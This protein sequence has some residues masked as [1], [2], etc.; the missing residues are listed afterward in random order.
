V[1][2]VEVE[3]VMAPVMAS[4]VR[5]IVEENVPAVAPVP[6][7]IATGVVV[8]VQKAEAVPKLKAAVGAAVMVTVLVAV[9]AAQPPEAATVLV[10]VK[11]PGMEA[12]RLMVPVAG[13]ML[14]PE[15]DENVPAVA[16]GANTTAGLLVPLT[17]NVLV[18]P[19]LKAAV[20]AAVMVTVAVAVAAAQPP[21]A[22]TV[23]VT[24]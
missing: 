21:E 2:G 22:A 4:R 18:G 1:P 13:S 19:K 9:A 8:V 6:S 15:V 12:A 3:G 16:P 5:P 10:T 20:G 17:Q 23:L 14:K 7:T 11:V 24:V